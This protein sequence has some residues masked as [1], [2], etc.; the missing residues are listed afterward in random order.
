[1]TLRKQAL[2]SRF[3]NSRDTR[4]RHTLERQ[5][6][7]MKR[8][9]AVQGLLLLCACSSAQYDVNPDGS[10]PVVYPATQVLQWPVVDGAHQPADAAVRI[11]IDPSVKFRKDVQLGDGVRI[12]AGAFMDNDVLLFHNVTVG[13]ETRIGR[14]AIVQADVKIGKKVL[15]DS[16]AKIGTGSIIEDGAKIGNWAIIGNG[17]SIGAN[18]TIGSSALIENGATVAESEVVPPSTRVQASK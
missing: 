6:G 4:D 14:D 17:A 16:D 13:E 15:I 12:G 10:K 2:L 18:S 7:Q 5:G 9:I 3:G 8:L 1:M 11:Y